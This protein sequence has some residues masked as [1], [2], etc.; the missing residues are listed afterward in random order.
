MDEVYYRNNNDESHPVELSIYLSNLTKTFPAS[1]VCYDD[2]VMIHVS[3][4]VCQPLNNMQCSTT[5]LEGKVALRRKGLASSTDRGETGSVLAHANA[6]QKEA[7]VVA[8]TA[9]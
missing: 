1:Y 5:L 7:R 4:A 9:L 2:L 3:L 8:R 6:S